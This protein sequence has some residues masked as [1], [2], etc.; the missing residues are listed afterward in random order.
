MIGQSASPSTKDDLGPR[1]FAGFAIMCFG[2]FMAILDVQIVAT[3]LPTIQ[4]AV[5]IAPEGISWVQTGY[6]IAEV[7]A[8]PLTGFLTRLLGMRRLF[9]GAILI[10]SLASLGCAASTS[11]AELIIWRI[12]QGLS[13]GTLIPAVFA[14]VFLLFP[15]RLQGVATTIAGSLAVHAPTVGPIAGGWITDTY[16]WHWLFMINVGPGPD[17]RDSWTRMASARAKRLAPSETVQFAVTHPSCHL[18]RRARNRAQ[19]SA[20]RWLD[21]A[22]R[23]LTSDLDGFGWDDPCMPDCFYRAAADRLNAAGR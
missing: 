7:V 14:S 4:K 18:S 19:A 21:L 10:F 6:L 20:A 15:V 23:Y 1:V 22:T 9:C 16:S 5:G 2:M 11:F 12:L 8:I 3:S 13:G 17:R